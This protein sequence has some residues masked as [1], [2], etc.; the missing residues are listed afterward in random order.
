[1]PQS[2]M[3]ATTRLRNVKIHRLGARWFDWWFAAP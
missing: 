2:L 3:L 1:M